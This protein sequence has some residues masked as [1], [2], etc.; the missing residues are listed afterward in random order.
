[1]IHW[2]KLVLLLLVKKFDDLQL[3]ASICTSYFITSRLGR[4]CCTFDRF[5]IVGPVGSGLVYNVEISK[6]FHPS[7]S[8]LSTQLLI[9]V[10]IVLL[11]LLHTNKSL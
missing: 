11:V 8:S 5:L 3:S 10:V 1:M 4:A 9:V 7:S 6:R 2:Q